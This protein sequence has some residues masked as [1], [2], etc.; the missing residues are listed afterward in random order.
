MTRG[1]KIGLSVLA[2]LCLLLA[3][4]GG[5]CI[6]ALSR[7]GR[8]ISQ[9]ANQSQTEGE[10]FG[11]SSDEAGCLKEALARNKKSN[12]ITNVV[13]I[14]VFLGTCL[15]QSEPTQGFCEGVPSR[16]ERDKVKAWAARKCAE[17][18]QRGLTCEAMFQV[19]L[20][21]CEGDEKGNPPRVEVPK[22]N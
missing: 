10:T 1:W 18:G 20:T 9:G 3:L 19:V 2:G 5:G 12:S 4:V 14:N 13:T 15:K 7:Y 8:Q 22:A 21:H 11:K 6:Y 17:V 16:E